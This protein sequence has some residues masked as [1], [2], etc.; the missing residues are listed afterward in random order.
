[1]AVRGQPGKLRAAQASNDA[2]VNPV[3]LQIPRDYRSLAARKA[4]PFNA[5]DSA[6]QAEK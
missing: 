6:A 4:K 2:A 5:Q 1:M 3:P